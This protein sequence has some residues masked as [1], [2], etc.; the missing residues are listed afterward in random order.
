MQNDGS[1]ITNPCEPRPRARGRPRAFDRETALGA[2]MRLFWQKGFEATSM[3]ELTE[4]MGIGSPS[5]YA[6]FGS[7]EALYA[8]AVRH[9]VDS[10]EHHA[11]T[12]FHSARTAREAVE[13]YLLA[14]ADALTGSLY[15]SPRGCMVTL[16]SVGCEGHA[17]LG[18]LVRSERSVSLERIKTR[19]DE[20]IESGEIPASTDIHALGRFVQT[21]QSG[22]SIL[23]RDGASSLELRS[24]AETAMLGW[25]ARTVPISP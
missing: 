16:S 10:Y 3:A 24:V 25:D 13:A 18:A 21:V 14:L 6:A 2:A 17:E 1:R 9:Y 19:L 4:A 7:K 5:L 22:M 23:A 8:E 20:A 11:W 15:E 12:C